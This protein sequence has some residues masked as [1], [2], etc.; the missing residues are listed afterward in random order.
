MS[1]AVQTAIMRAGVVGSPGTAAVE[2]APVPRPGPREVLVR[3]EGCGV[4]ASSLPV[5]EGRPW[6]DYPLPAGAPGH[7]GW[8]VE[9]ESGRRV[10]FLGER[11]F[12]EYAVAAEEHTVPLPA[13][14]DGVPFP[15]EAFACAVN[16]VRRSDLRP[17]QDV[18][19]VGVGFLGSAVA[20]L[21]RAGGARVT[22]A[23]RGTRVEGEFERVI[24]A[25]GTQGALDAAASLVATRGRLV[26][27]G[28]HQDGP[29][30]VDL[31]LWNWRGIDVVNAH[32]RDALE[33]V[34]GMREAV[35]LAAEGTL[36]VD[37][38]VTHRFPLDR[39]EEAFEAARTR[40]HG[41]VKAWVAP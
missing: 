27:A 39:L 4:C 11:A 6:F 24:E 35:R 22:E 33:Y 8:G 34:A 15:G 5:W 7:E 29:R 30:Q 17:G 31:Q 38:L 12:A 32:E 23:R 37:T 36:D 3:V 14:L 28:Y 16:V 13:A 2:T 10:T 40:P 20:A 19:I 26:I 21:A 41:F 25:A 9:V 1:I 18:A